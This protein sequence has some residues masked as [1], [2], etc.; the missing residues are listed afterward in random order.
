MPKQ[1][2]GIDWKWCH[3]IAQWHNS[4]HYVIVTYYQ[5]LIIV[6]RVCSLKSNNQI[7]SHNRGNESFE[8]LSGWNT[9]VFECTNLPLIWRYGITSTHNVGIGKSR[10]QKWP[11]VKR[12]S[13]RQI[14]MSI[15]PQLIK[16]IQRNL[17]VLVRHLI[18]LM[19]LNFDSIGQT[20]QKKTYGLFGTHI[21]WI[22]LYIKCE[23]GW[24]LKLPSITTPMLQFT[25][26]NGQAQM[27]PSHDYQNKFNVQI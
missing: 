1:E 27:N 2:K 26:V 10:C 9:W 24:S 20:K 16:K 25:Y 15:S 4:G 11:L 8:Q 5:K 14:K 18:S 13:Q 12:C 3:G 23:S 22:D 17:G 6:V 19:S 21:V 7:A